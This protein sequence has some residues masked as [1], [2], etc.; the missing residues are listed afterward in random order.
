MTNPLLRKNYKSN[1]SEFLKTNLNKL[2]LIDKVEYLWHLV[3][4]DQL[5]N[6]TI[7]EN[8]DK[9]SG[10]TQTKKNNQIFV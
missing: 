2:D 8:F 7:K 10:V 9:F 6:E 5:I 1:F 3:P 4:A